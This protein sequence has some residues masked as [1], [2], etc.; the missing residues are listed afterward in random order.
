[1]RLLQSWRKYCRS[2][3]LHSDARAEEKHTDRTS[4]VS[5]EDDLD[6]FVEA[7]S[8]VTDGGALSNDNTKTRRL[9]RKRHADGG[10]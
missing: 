10:N 2:A 3:A 6:F 1:M 8:V 9:A 4:V 5:L 7:A